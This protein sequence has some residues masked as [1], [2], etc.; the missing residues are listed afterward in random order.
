MKL[1]HI[2][3]GIIITILISILLGCSKADQEY[4]VGIYWLEKEN[5]WQMA[6]KA[7]RRSLD[8]EPNKWKTHA[9]LIE[10]LSRGEEPNAFQQQLRQTLSI[11]PD[12]ARSPTLVK[13]SAAILGG[14]R[15]DRLA[16]SYELRYIGDLL[17]RKGEDPFLLSRGIM[18]SCRTRDTV[19]VVDY[20]S[21]LLTVNKGTDIPDSVVQEMNFFIGPSQVEWLRYEWRIAQSPN[22][23]DLRIA[24]LE[25]GIILGDSSAVRQQLTKI[26]SSTPEGSFK[27]EFVKQFGLLTGYDPY[28]SKKIARGWDG[29]FSP[30]GGHIVYVKNIGTEKNPDLYLYRTPVKG[31]QEVPIMKAAQQV[32][33]SVSWPKFSPDG[34]WIYFYGSRNKGWIPG[35]IGR[36]HL[37]RVS[38]EYG[39]KP[40]K[41]TDSDLLTVVP[42]F[43][44]AGTI[45]L[46]RRDVGSLRSS[47]E[48]VRLNPGERTLEVISR[49]GEPVS[50]AT[51]TPDGDSLVFVTDRGIFR[52]SI[53][54]GTIHVDLTWIGLQYPQISKGNGN[55]F[56]QNRKGHLLYINRDNSKPTFL[57]STALPIVGF[58]SKGKILITRM[59]DGSRHVVLLDL[60]HPLKST[61]QFIATIKA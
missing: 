14:E 38:P 44:K 2:I 58:G 43:E 30:D 34:K 8:D 53:S 55:L 40:Q 5:N 28:N 61:N 33:S 60:D 9:M 39:G 27:P 31:G 7:F 20:F 45:L 1:R 6:A 4:R 21:R 52:R 35:E 47:V 17:A 42:F 56:F 22:D 24:Q 18:A 36:F 49:I 25:V 23:M 26:A 51:F 48:I 37:Y 59:I 16:S 3:S 11:F 29:A 46:V 10:A 13:P 19:A 50:G 32:L 54:G 41:L 12:S 57:G 15:Y